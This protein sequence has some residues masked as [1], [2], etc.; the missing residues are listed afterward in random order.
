MDEKSADV[1]V[2]PSVADPI[3]VVGHAKPQG[4]NPAE[5]KT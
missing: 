5:L 4:R 2:I 3:R 1:N